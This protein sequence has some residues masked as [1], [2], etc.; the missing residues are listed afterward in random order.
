MEMFHK[1]VE[2][3]DPL[4]NN[5]QEEVKQDKLNPGLTLSS[6]VLT[7]NQKRKIEEVIQKIIE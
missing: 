1:E 6:I 7:F 5:S 4:V 3:I 2:D